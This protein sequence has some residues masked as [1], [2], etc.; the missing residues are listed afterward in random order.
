M[1]YDISNYTL[2]NYFKTEC[3]F[4]ILIVQLNIYYLVILKLIL[5]AEI[6]K[7]K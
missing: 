7:V 6:Y 5:F 3:L 2:I 4:F 1:I